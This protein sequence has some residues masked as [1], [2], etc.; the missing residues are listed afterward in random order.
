MA[1]K[2]FLI[3]YGRQIACHEIGLEGQKKLISSSVLIVGCG[4][5]GS[6]IGMELAGAGIGK[7]GIADFDNIEE[8]NLQ[9]QFFFKTSEA[10]KSKA[11]I[12]GKRF[13][14]LNPLVK[15][16]IYPFLITKEKAKTLF[17]LYDFI[18]DASDNPDSKRIVDEIS[19]LYS[20]P[21]CIGGVK[22]F[23]GQVITLFPEDPRFDEIFGSASSGGVMPCS[24]S[25]VMG[26]AAAICASLQAMEV[27]KYF[28]NS[29]ELLR[30]RLLVFN[31]LQDKFSIFRLD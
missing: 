27:I 30:R 1:E 23:G 11:E 15:V 4:A 9:R 14:E 3:R 31:L 7:I 29:G 12:L 19:C 17:P 22:D 5:L 21:C 6:M 20:K 28:T 24:I 2:D 16:E 25:G 8:S 10:G 13:E 18:V 26:P